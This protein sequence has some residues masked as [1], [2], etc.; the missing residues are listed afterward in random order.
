MNLRIK[1]FLML[2]VLVITFQLFPKPIKSQ[3]VDTQKFINS[4][5]YVECFLINDDKSET[6][7]EC[8]SFPMS[9][10]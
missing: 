2:S 4:G 6:R 5:E 9:D 1:S 8:D 7:V 3:E 10:K